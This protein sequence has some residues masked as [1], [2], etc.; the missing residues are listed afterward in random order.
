MVLCFVHPATRPQE[1]PERRLH[2]LK[3]LLDVYYKRI[4]FRSKHVDYDKF[5]YYPDQWD[6]ERKTSRYL[7]KWEKYYDDRTVMLEHLHH[8]WWAY[9]AVLEMGY[10]ADLETVLEIAETKE[11]ALNHAPAKFKYHPDVKA[12]REL[13]EF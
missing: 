4:Y 11:A 8:D 7:L 12:A 2:D 5:P 10:G 9:E 6:S 13:L 1:L 3:G